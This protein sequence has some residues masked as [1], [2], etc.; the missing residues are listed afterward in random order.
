MY[1]SDL[2]LVHSVDKVEYAFLL[3]NPPYLAVTASG[4]ADSDGWSDPELQVRNPTSPL[5]DGILEFDFLARPPADRRVQEL[6]P[7]RAEMIWKEDAY[8]IRGVRVFSANDD[9]KVIFATG[10]Q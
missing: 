6:T 2:K 3:R 10:A 9:V 1:S 5:S 8:S 4:Q 7:I